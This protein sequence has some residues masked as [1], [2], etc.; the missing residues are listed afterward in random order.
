[1]ENW[2]VGKNK[3]T[4]ITDSSEGLKE[5]TGHT[6]KYAQK[7][8]G[9]NL[10]CESIFRKKDASLIAA[11]PDMLEALR[12]LIDPITGLVS[13][14]IAQEIGL[15]KAYEIEH[16]IEKAQKLCKKTK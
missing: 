2:K 9:G 12:G 16:A 10:I 14:F 1:M 13:D 8:Y 4:V 7:H 3:M 15:K 5:Y 11:A 6:G